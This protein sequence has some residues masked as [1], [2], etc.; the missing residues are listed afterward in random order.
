MSQLIAWPSGGCVQGEATSHL[1]RINRVEGQRG[2]RLRRE[3]RESPANGH[4]DQ[5]TTY[6]LQ[7][8]LQCFLQ[9]QLGGPGVRKQCSPLTQSD[10]S[11]LGG[12][13]WVKEQAKR[14]ILAGGMSG[15]LESHGPQRG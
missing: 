7:K 9:L 13:L 2:A 6:F 15:T 14:L 3:A 4:H 5:P 8:N 1:S 11:L 12:D 10:L